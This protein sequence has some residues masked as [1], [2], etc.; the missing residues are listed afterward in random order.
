MQSQNSGKISGYEIILWLYSKTEPL[1]AFDF[2]FDDGI[3]RQY[4][5]FDR[6]LTAYREGKTNEHES[7]VMENCLI[8]GRE[9][10]TV[11]MGLL[12]QLGSVVDFN[13]EMLETVFKKIGTP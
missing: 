2:C 8:D 3:L 13:V 9:I 1:K 12:V 7:A 4:F 6:M 10:N 11:P 5:E